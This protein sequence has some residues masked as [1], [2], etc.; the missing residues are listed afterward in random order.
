MRGVSRR[1]PSIRLPARGRPP[2]A[3]IPEKGGWHHVG[4]AFESRQRVVWA[5]AAEGDSAA[6]AVTATSA[7]PFSTTT[8]TVGSTGSTT[9]AS[10]SVAAT[11]T[12]TAVGSATLPPGTLPALDAAGSVSLPEASPLSP[13]SPPSARPAWRVLPPALEGVL[14]LQLCAALFGSNQVA[15][16]AVEASLSPALAAAVRFSLAAAVFAPAAARGLRDPAIRA[17][18]LELGAWLAL[19]YGA[20]ALGLAHSTAARGAFT[21]AFTIFTVPAL[22][23][24]LGGRRVPPAVWALASLALAGVGLL[25]AADGPPPSLADA[26]LIA[27]ALLFGVH[28]W[29]CE[30]ATL[31]AVARER[32][33]GG[34]ESGTDEA[35]ADGL[36]GVQLAVLAGAACLAA[37][38]ELLSSA[39]AGDLTATLAPVK[40]HAA[41]LAYIGVVTTGLTLRWEVEALKVVPAHTAALIYSSEMVWG[42]AGAWCLGGERWGVAGWVGAVCVAA[43]SVG[44]ARL[45]AGG[46]GLEGDGEEKAE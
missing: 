18:G 7:P 37:A 40:A 24:G 8:T 12:T 32:A 23:A 19:G 36:T 1:P 16:K 45:G 29:R 26:A 2:T 17:S 27:S 34:G 46:E 9:T 21:G 31:A 11:T 20:Q 44:A 22:A 43:A 4:H 5:A 28:K 6:A 38:P 39:A 25:T 14:L 3:R 33:E 10:P 30:G 35:A 13:P 41:S 42:A 15:V